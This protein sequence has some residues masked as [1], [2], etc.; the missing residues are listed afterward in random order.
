MGALLLLSM[1]TAA[2]GGQGAAQQ[3]AEPDSVASDP[4]VA[5]PVPVVTAV[6]G[7]LEQYRQ[8]Y[9][10]RS[11][12]ALAPLYDTSASLVQVWQGRTL[13]GWDDV[14][15]DLDIR[16]GRAENVRLRIRD[17]R[18]ATLGPDG[19]H[20]T[21][22]LA[23]TISDGVTAIQEDGVLT[24]TLRRQEQRWVIVGEHFSYPPRRQ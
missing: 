3:A 21:A 13:L 19:A 10:V 14:K 23:R 11:V 18:V 17:T 16:L 2:C 6:A 22:W 15:A 7:V 9:E 24:L 4:D 12:E 5:A 8:G 1:I 20:V